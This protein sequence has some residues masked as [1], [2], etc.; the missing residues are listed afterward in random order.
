MSLILPANGIAMTERVDRDRPAAP[1][2]PGVQFLLD[3]GQRGRH[4]GLVDRGHEQADGDDSEDKLAPVFL[5]SLS[6]GAVWLADFRD[7]SR[8]AHR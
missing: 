4:D 1:V 5:L 7:G 3:R 2:D 8:Y 6:G